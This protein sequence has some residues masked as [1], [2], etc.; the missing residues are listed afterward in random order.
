M[1]ERLKEAK[2]A[3]IKWPTKWV[4]C[5]DID[6]PKTKTKKYIRIGL[7]KVLGLE[8]DD[9]EES[10]PPQKETKA[11]IDWG[12]ISGFR[13]C[14]ACYV[15]FMHIGSNESWGAWNNLR[16]F[17]WHVHVF[18]TLGGFS[19]ASPMNPA[20][21]TKFSYFLARIGQMYP[22]YAAALV[23]GLVNLLVV[24]RP[25][26]FRPNFHWNSQ[27]D[28]LYL[29]T[30]EVAPLFCEGTPATP[31]SYWASLG[32]TVVTYIFGLAVTPF[33]PI[34]WWMGY[35]LWFSS[36][37]YQCLAVFPALYNFLF[38]RVRKNTKLL[39]SMIVGLLVLNAGIIAAAWLTMRDGQGF[40]H[41]EEP[42]TAR[43]D[44]PMEENIF[45]H[46]S[47]E[48]VV[49]PSLEAAEGQLLSPGELANI[50]VL[51]FYLLGPFW[52]LYF[53]LGACTAFLYDAMRPAEKHSAYL[54]GWTADAITV[55]MMTLSV[56]HILQGSSSNSS[57]GSHEL[58]MRPDE[59][60]QYYTDV[61]IVHRLWDNLNGR[62][63][64]PL[65]TLWVFSVSTGRGWTAWILGNEFLVDVL[66]P[67][68]Y[69]CFLFHQFVSQ[70]YYAATRN[71]HWW[72]W[73]RY[74][75]DFYWFSPGPCPVEWYEYFF[76]V[77]L[78]VLFSQLMEDRIMPIS[79]LAFEVV[80]EFVVGPPEADE[81][82]EEPIGDVLCQIVEKMTGIEA[83]H[84]HTLEECG[85]ASVG[86][87]VL[88]GLLNKRFSTNGKA[89]GITAADMV[90]A[91]AIADMAEIVET[92]QD[93]AD[94][95]GV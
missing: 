41:Y 94:D 14:L 89:L 80:H 39:L 13:F 53:V 93:L 43:S 65:T 61:A 5:Q 52:A 81:A 66:A 76:V 7:A 8:G 49:N 64:A 17:P 18:F 3:P 95:Q 15:M 28:D 38:R 34:N 59:A 27:P 11:R 55:I 23:F 85:L 58:Y 50:Q 48:I 68:S 67:N 60:D 25:S 21:K 71:G 79:R 69:N 40:H 35:Y 77:G 9:D 46:R 90:G 56:A 82:E 72:N 47:D 29:E 57:N 16:G 74:R 87:P 75:K 83:E 84:D 91:N 12:A 78:V 1:R 31:D 70:W 63:V 45:A 20:I 92:A 62:L 26:T 73:W 44:D 2:L 32:L 54:W 22:M 6:L 33:W 10:L 19:L 24:C 42:D 36:M 30:G 88:V 37:Y 86:I 51:S 4:I